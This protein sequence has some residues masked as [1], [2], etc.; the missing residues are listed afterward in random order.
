MGCAFDY[1]FL[2]VAARL[3][4]AEQRE[5]ETRKIPSIVSGYLLEGLQDAAQRLK[6]FF[7]LTYDLFIALEAI[8]DLTERHT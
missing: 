2:E 8:D 3:A 5:I 6:L 1:D 4:A 7:E